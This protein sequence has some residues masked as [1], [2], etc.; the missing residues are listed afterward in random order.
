[1][2]T[3]LFR[4]AALAASLLAGTV[5]L[6][7]A[8]NLFAPRAHVNGSVITQFE[9]QQRQ[10]M[11]ELFNAPDNSDEAALDALI[12]ERLQV[13]EA[14]RLGLGIT[15][16]ELL[17]GMS[18]FASRANLGREEFVAQI[19]R[20]G[21]DV[22]SYEDFV[23]AGLAWRKVLAD[24]FQGRIIVDS[25]DTDRALN[26]PPAPKL[27][28]LLNELIIPANTPDRAARAESLAPY[29]SSITSFAEFRAAARQYSATASRD[30]GGAIDWLDLENLPPQLR[31]VLLAL[32][33]GEVT[34]PVR[35][36]NALAFFQLREVDEV[37]QPATPVSVEYATFL[38]PGGKSE[39]GYQQAAQIRASVDTC[40][41][42]YTVARGSNPEQLERETRPIGQVPSDVAFELAKLDPGEVS[43][44][45]TRAGGQTLVFLMLCER[46]YRSQD[47]E[48]PDPERLRSALV[49][50][51]ANA[52][53]DVYLSDLRANATIRY[54]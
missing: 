38:I 44:N 14:R 49:N 11:F 18:E 34:Q 36:P 42:L 51:Q 9:V 37:V 33:P 1:M 19:G 4:I 8:Q 21:V 50:R 46:S 15:E 3:R 54:E 20:A 23:R 32:K 6:A 7:C 31:G 40:D 35:L 2:L 27:R 5:P 41:D 53:A 48:T 22:E 16:A 52:A 12:N 13:A 24:R 17:E 29:I 25:D 10:I 28:V 30:R 26:S 39:L 43:T 47:A 45:L